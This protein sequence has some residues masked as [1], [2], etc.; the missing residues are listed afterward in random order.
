MIT[1]YSKSPTWLCTFIN[2]TLDLPKYQS[3]FLTRWENAV[4]IKESFSSFLPK[5][6]WYSGSKSSKRTATPGR[7]V[8]L[9]ALPV[10][11]L[12]KIW[13]CNYGF[14]FYP[15][16]IMLMTMKSFSVSIPWASISQKEGKSMDHHPHNPFGTRRHL[17]IHFHLSLWTVFLIF[18]LCL[19][20]KWRRSSESGCSW[21]PQLVRLLVERGFRLLSQQP[22]GSV[23]KWFGQ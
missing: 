7:L 4:L 16:Q 8:Y 14:L 6:R 21:S 11:I 17:I 15:I 18:A 2:F 9:S 1:D 12:H 5:W 13:L 10:I 3:H 22:K 23:T 19:V 20:P